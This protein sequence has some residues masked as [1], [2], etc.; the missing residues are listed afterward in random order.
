MKRGLLGIFVLLTVFYFSSK[1]SY[2][3]VRK[4]LGRSYVSAE[5]W[6][7]IQEYEKAKRALERI[8]SDPKSSSEQVFYSKVLLAQIYSEGRELGKSL[9]LYNSISS[10]REYDLPDEHVCKYLDLLRRNGL[11]SRAIEVTKRY[12]SSLSL[13]DRFVNIESALNSYYQYYQSQ[14]AGKFME[15]SAVRTPSDLEN[16][17]AYGI[18]PYGSDY[19]L[20]MNRY[21]YSNTQ[22]FYTNARMILLSSHRKGSSSIMNTS[23]AQLGG[24]VQ[25]GPATFFNDSKSVIFTANQYNKYNTGNRPYGSV[26]NLQL[27][28][29]TMRSN[30]QWT[31]PVNISNSFTRKASSYS[32]LAPSVD[33]KGKVLYFASDMKGG[34]GGTDIYYCKY[35]EKRNRWG[36]PVNMGDQVNT[37]G[38]ELYPCVKND[39]LLFSSNGLLGYG[40]QDIFMKKISATNEPAVHLPYP[41]NTQFKDTN[42]MFDSKSNTIFFASDRNSQKVGYVLEQVYSLVSSLTD[43]IARGGK[44]PVE[45]KP[46]QKDTTGIDQIKELVADKAKPSLKDTLDVI[47][48]DFN[49]YIINKDQYRRLDSIYAN[50]IANPGK[51]I[52][53]ID[54]HTDVTGTERYNLSLSEMRAKSVMEYLIGKGIPKN[55][56]EI[57]WFGFSRPLATCNKETETDKKCQEINALNRRCEVYIKRIK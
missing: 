21:N 32:F 15:V 14:K 49:K 27:Y 45:E 30:G 7:K 43:L 53:S 20:L 24:F 9:E 51:Y 38:D 19:I 55:V 25:Q 47:H 18:I 2:G 40:D 48:F 35:D 39:T 42:P 6:V 10:D 3:Q 41:V 8:I 37:N 31:R 4:D 33:E 44:L 46:A 50:F 11:I 5:R 22:S 34:F 13:N 17:Y 28:L 12:H 16:S 57:Q 56:F 36:T 52:V 29:S 23:F 26:N 1:N 54:G